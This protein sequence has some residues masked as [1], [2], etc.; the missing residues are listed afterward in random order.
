MLTL[1][2][3]G[4]HGG[5]TSTRDALRQ[6]MSLSTAPKIMGLYEVICNLVSQYC[7]SDCCLSHIVCQ[8]ECLSVLYKSVVLNLESQIHLS[9]VALTI[10]T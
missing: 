8:A 1:Q 6:Q 4:M 10:Q 3:C 9:I 5:G 2:A 7:V